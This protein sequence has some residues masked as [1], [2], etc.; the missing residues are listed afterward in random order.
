MPRGKILYSKSCIQ[1]WLW[2]KD[3]RIINKMYFKKK[4]VVI[5]EIAFLQ[6]VSLYYYISLCYITGLLYLIH[7]C[8]YSLNVVVMQCSSFNVVICQRGANSGNC[9]Y[10]WAVQS[11]GPVVEGVFNP[12]TEIRVQ[13]PQFIHTLLQVEDLLSKPYLS[14]SAKVVSTKRTWINKSKSAYYALEWSNQELYYYIK[15]YWSFITDA[16]M[17]KQHS[18]VIAGKGGAYFNYF[19]HCWVV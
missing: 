12:Y 17:Y 6:S 16:L 15:C 4:K 3:R 19:I 10:C 13:I 2:W 14:K 1:N 8:L 7:W 5:K 11:L 18:N 9:I